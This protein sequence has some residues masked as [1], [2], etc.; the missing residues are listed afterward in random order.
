MINELKA[1]KKDV[2]SHIN[3][4]NSAMSDVKNSEQALYL[5]DA[6]NFEKGQLNMLNLIIYKYEKELQNIT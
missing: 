3:N 1:L 6:I 4:Y 5:K 2:E